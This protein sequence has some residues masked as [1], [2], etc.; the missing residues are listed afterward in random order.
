MEFIGVQ[1]TQIDKR[2]FSDAGLL[3]RGKFLSDANSRF[4]IISISVLWTDIFSF[5]K[6][7]FLND[8]DNLNKKTYTH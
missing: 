1:I 2:N 5:K 4:S 3:I 7:H 6:K 8:G